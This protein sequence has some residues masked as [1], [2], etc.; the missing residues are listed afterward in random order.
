MPSPYFSRRSFLAQS[1][2]ALAAPSLAH[3]FGKLGKVAIVGAGIAGLSCGKA[4]AKRGYQ[5]QIFE[6]RSRIGG[7]LHTDMGFGFPLELGSAWTLATGTSSA[8]ATNI[9]EDGQKLFI[10]DWE[11]MVQSDEGKAVP[12]E[13]YKEATMVAMR[14]LRV[15]AEES[16]KLGPTMSVRSALMAANSKVFQ[17]PNGRLAL[18]IAAETNTGANIEDLAGWW[19]PTGIVGQRAAPLGGWATY[20]EK[21]ASGLEIRFQEA[22]SNIAFDKNGVQLDLDSGS[23]TADFAVICVPLGVLRSR[24]FT[25]SG[26][27]PENW[28]DNLRRIHVGALERVVLEFEKRTWPRGS[29]FADAGNRAAPCTYFEPL[30][31]ESDRPIL[32]GLVAAD[33]AMPDDVGDAALRQLRG[34]LGSDLPEP[35]RTKVT[36]WSNDPYALGATAYPPP[37]S[38]SDD[39]NKAA[40]PFGDRIFFAGDYCSLASMGTVHGAYLSGTR[41]AEQVANR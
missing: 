4:L 21:L 28:L 16:V 14:S 20:C 10:D 29:R 32:V 26:A 41:A 1:A 2:A 13:K 17:D 22:V 23:V 11:W 12:P 7:R 35:V 33:A 40:I 6:A 24:D 34:I 19:D 31:G 36:R 30:V 37:G 18:S 3:H 39:F 8:V 38:H 5:V 27:V 25:I 15:A 9:V